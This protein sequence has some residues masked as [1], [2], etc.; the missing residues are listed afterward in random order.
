MAIEIGMK[1]ENVKT[2]EIAE[3]IEINEKSK[4]CIV[5]LP[6][7]KTMSYSNTTIKDKRRWIPVNE[8]NLQIPKEALTF[9]EDIEEIKVDDKIIVTS[10]VDAS[11][12]ISDTNVEKPVK[13]RGTLIEFDGRQ[14]TL[15]AWAKELDFAPQTLYNRIYN[16][17]WSVEK[18]LTTKK[19]NK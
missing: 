13:K 12:L 8:I 4:T 5:E 9:I 17:G 2:K 16:M 7:G 18:A 3:V 10:T 11:K 15:G 6:S 14:Q 1:F 19:G